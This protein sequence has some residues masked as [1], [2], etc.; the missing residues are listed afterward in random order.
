MPSKLKEFQEQIM[1]DNLIGKS[2]KKNPLS[3]LVM[4]LVLLGRAV[5][6]PFNIKIGLSFN[7]LNESKF[8][9]CKQSVDS[10]ICADLCNFMSPNFV[11]CE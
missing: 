7:T 1:I 5:C 8:L 11:F 9:I 4:R 6:A 3:K 10:A 2:E